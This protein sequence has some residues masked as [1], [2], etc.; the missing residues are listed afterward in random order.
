[1]LSERYVYNHS[2]NLNQVICNVLSNNL[3][4]VQFITTHT[5]KY[6]ILKCQIYKS[7]S[8]YN[9]L[10]NK[11]T[12]INNA[13]SALTKTIG[14]LEEKTR[15]FSTFNWTYRIVYWRNTPQ[16]QKLGIRSK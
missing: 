14:I 2:F 13:L 9:T 11:S 6:V 8:K 15:S 4:N 16:T 10:R 12:I 7:N 3:L 5:L 1:M